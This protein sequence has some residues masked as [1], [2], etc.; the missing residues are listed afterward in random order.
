MLDLVFIIIVVGLAG[1]TL[2]YGGACDLLL[3]T[4]VTRD[5]GIDLPESSAPSP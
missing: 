5:A 4:D 1:A 2:L 3:R